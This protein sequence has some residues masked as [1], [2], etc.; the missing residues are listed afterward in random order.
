[1]QI[2]YKQLRKSCF[3]TVLNWVAKAYRLSR[4][5]IELMTDDI[6]QEALIVL[7][8]NIDTF[9]EKKSK[10]TTYYLLICKGHFLNDW[11]KN[12]TKNKHFSRNVDESAFLIEGISGEEEIGLFQDEESKKKNKVLV[13]LA[14]CMGAL[15]EKYRNIVYWM[16][17]DNLE[18]SEISVRM[19]YE[20]EDTN[21][22]ALK[23]TAFRRLLK[24][25]KG[26]GVEN[27]S[28]FIND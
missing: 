16:F 15:E 14:D 1:M 17:F 10:I 7:S 23:N 12:K 22:Y 3:R 24:C 5:E 8:Q 6:M 13:F 2:D 28:A 9:D 20:P 4:E 18:R 11:R 21:I 26:K 25:L 19:G 27:L